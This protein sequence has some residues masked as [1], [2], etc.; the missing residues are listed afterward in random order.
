MKHCWPN[1]IAFS[2]VIT[3]L[4]SCASQAD[5]W[6]SSCY[7]IHSCL[8]TAVTQFA[9]SNCVTAVEISFVTGNTLLCDWIFEYTEHMYHYAC[10]SNF[11][12][13]FLRD[14]QVYFE[15]NASG[16]THLGSMTPWVCSRRYSIPSSLLR[17]LGLQVTWLWCFVQI[18]TERHRIDFFNLVFFLKVSRVELRSIIQ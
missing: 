14:I 6:G 13:T 3:E 8:S 11:R 5:L 10:G 7:I 17:F 2:V 16:R 15:D 12:E 1:S 18:S 9:T 4:N